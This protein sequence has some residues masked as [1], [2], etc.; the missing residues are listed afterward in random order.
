MELIKHPLT[1][2]G[3]PGY[4]ERKHTDKRKATELPEAR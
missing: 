3:W 4:I 1:C 2:T